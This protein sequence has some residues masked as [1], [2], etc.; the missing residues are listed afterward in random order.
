MKKLLAGLILA[1]IGLGVSYQVY[2]L[3]QRSQHREKKLEVKVPVKVSKVQHRQMTQKLDL[4]G[5]IKPKLKLAKA[6][7][8]K[9]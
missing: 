2:K 3:Y 9:S 7:I 4:I 6:D 5:N 1:I 8:Y